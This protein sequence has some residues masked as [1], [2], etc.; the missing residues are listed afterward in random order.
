MNN[1]AHY[2]SIELEDAE[3]RVVAG[4]VNDGCSL[5]FATGV[6]YVEDYHL[7]WPTNLTDRLRNVLSGF[8][9]YRHAPFTARKLAHKIDAAA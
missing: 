1:T 6:V 9:T 8:Y 2:V 3:I 5:L 4:M 7:C